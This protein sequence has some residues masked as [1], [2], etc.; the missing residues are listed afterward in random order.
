MSRLLVDTH[1]LLWWLDDASEL[2][3]PARAAIADPAVEPLVS[4]A[5][6]WEIAI[7]TSLGKLTVPAELPDEIDDAGF[8]WLPVGADHDA[9]AVDRQEADPE[10]LLNLTRRLIA[11]R[12][13][14]PA[15]MTGSITI[16]EAGEALLL[17]ERVA[18][19]RTLFC[20]FN[21]GDRAVPAP[22]SLEGRRV[23]ESLNGATTELLPPF[24]ALIAE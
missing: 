21:L 5:S 18:D 6:L 20:A 13:A 1:A 8:T 19:G 23:I 10:S 4:T 22:A 2:S 7:K 24:A 11:L 15:L 12:H 14:N 3:G 16:R 9:L 17:F